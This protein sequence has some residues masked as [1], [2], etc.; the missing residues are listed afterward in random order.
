MSTSTSASSYVAFQVDKEQDKEKQIVLILVGLIGSGKST[1]AEALEQHLPGRFRRCNQ[2]DLGDRKRVEK[3]ARHTLREGL[4]V[5]IDRTN[6]N[7][8]QRSYWINIARE[9]PGTLVWIIVFDTPYEICAARLQSRRFHPTIT[10]PEQG[11]SILNRFANDFR[12]P[13]ADEGYQRLIG[14]TPSD[15]PSPMYTPAQIISILQRLQNSTP[16]TAVCASSESSARGNA[17][18]RDHYIHGRKDRW[19]N[20]IPRTRGSPFGHKSAAPLG[21]FKLKLPSSKPSTSFNR[22]ARNTAPRPH[23]HQRS[24]DTRRS[25]RGGSSDSSNWRGS[26][27]AE[28]PLTIP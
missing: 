8:E 22:V 3:L 23:N 4:S 14:L 25:S 26:S 13:S 15:H 6:I 16:P 2:D 20:G 1:F 28:D 5:C 10:S 9:F 27:S 18:F 11:L 12:Y 17:V 7:A 24:A 21:S 19:S